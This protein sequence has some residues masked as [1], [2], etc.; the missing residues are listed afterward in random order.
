[1]FYLIPSSSVASLP[2]Q[3]VFKSIMAYLIN[4]LATAASPYIM[5]VVEMNLTP[6]F[7]VRFGKARL[8]PRSFVSHPQQLYIFVVARLVCIIVWLAGCLPDVC[9]ILYAVRLHNSVGSQVTQ[10]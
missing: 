3:D 6:D 2:L 4:S 7:L 5:P 9:V 8:Q 10:D 1:M